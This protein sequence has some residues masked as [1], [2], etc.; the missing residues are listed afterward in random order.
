MEN[1]LNLY[2][3]QGGTIND[4]T[5]LK[6]YT[7]RGYEIPM[8]KTYVLQWEFIP[9]KL[10]SKYLKAPLNGYFIGDIKFP[11]QS[12]SDNTLKILENSLLVQFINHGEFYVRFA[13]EQSLDD[14]GIQVYSYKDI[15]SSTGLLSSEKYYNYVTKLF[16]EEDNKIKVSINVK[17]KSFEHTFNIN[18]IFTLNGIEKP[19]IYTQITTIYTGENLN[20]I[21]DGLE[22]VNSEF[23]QTIG[24]TKIDLIKLNKTSN[25]SVIQQIFEDSV[26]NIGVYFPFVRYAGDYYQDKVS[27]NFIAADT[28]LVLEEVR[29]KDNAFD[30]VTPYISASSSYS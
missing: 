1:N 8:Q 10:A 23:Y 2:D 18:D 9:G 16:L 29:N 21:N 22:I 6:F 27:A 15:E 19:E 11:K 7:G 24:L 13:S 5:N 30:Y 17:N 14:N 12:D 26:P 20:T 3:N 28:I 4:I 25:M